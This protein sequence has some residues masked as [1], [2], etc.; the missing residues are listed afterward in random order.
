MATAARI[1]VRERIIG[2]MAFT[3]VWILAAEMGLAITAPAAGVVV[4]AG[5]WTVRGNATIIDHGWGVYSGFW[6]Q[7]AIQVV[8]GKWWSLG[9][10]IGLVGGTGRVTGAHL[11]WELWVNGVQVDPLDWLN[12]TYP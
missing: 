12:Q 9:D 4:F 10:V 11:H 3:Q 5:P 6:H 7:S 1:S 8:V 2:A